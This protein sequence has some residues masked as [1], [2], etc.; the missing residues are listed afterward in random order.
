MGVLDGAVPKVAKTLIAKFGTPGTLRLR[1]VSSY[2]T[3]TRVNTPAVPTDIPLKGVIEPYKARFAKARVE[4]TT[5]ADLQITIAAEELTAY[6]APTAKDSYLI[7]GSE[8][9]I[10]NVDSVYG[11]DSVALYVLHVVR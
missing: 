2:N 4:D 7:G 8:H 3:L 9:E 5:S 11:G 10:V 6:R 1:G